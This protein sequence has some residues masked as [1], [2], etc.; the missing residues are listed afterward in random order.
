VDEENLMRNRGYPKLLQHMALHNELAAKAGILL[1]Q[2]AHKQST[3]S[4]DVAKFLNQWL[5]NHILEHDFAMI[6]W[7]QENQKPS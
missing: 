3:T 7:I 2:Y 5:I 1:D 4:V 6:R